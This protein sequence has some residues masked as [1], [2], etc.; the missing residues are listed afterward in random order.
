MIEKSQREILELKKAITNLKQ[1]LEGI[2][3]G[4][5]QA[6]EKVCRFKDMAI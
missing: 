1:S 3:V 4:L 5:D 2:N 6:E